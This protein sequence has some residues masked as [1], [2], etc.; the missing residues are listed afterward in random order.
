MQT[1]P[2]GDSG[3]SAGACR[4]SYRGWIPDEHAHGRRVEAV[5]RIVDLRTVGDH[6]N[7]IHVRRDV[8]VVAACGDAVDDGEIPRRIDRHVHEEVQVGDDV[9]F[10]QAVSGK[11]D[12]EILPAGVLVFRRL[13]E[14]HRVALAGTAPRRGVV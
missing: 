8:D 7:H 4:T 1:G 3:S 9:S 5:A 10:G 13:P 6:E 2:R 14:T 12:D 11:L